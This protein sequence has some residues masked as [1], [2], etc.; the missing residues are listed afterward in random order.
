MRP[1]INQSFEGLPWA[2]VE[3]GWLSET[4]WIIC[5]DLYKFAIHL[6]WLI[7]SNKLVCYFS[8]VIVAAVAHRYLLLSDSSL[9]P[10]FV[11]FF[12]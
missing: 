5:S 9:T 7:P 1:K 4:E 12:D 2:P 10:V 11:I 8:I 3:V 6:S